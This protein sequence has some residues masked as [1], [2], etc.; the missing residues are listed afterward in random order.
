MMGLPLQ[1]GGSI[2]FGN[3]RYED[4]TGEGMLV[5]ADELIFDEFP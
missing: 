5:E 2:P 4:C 1:V 3:V